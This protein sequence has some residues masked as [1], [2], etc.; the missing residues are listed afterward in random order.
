LQ[1]DLPIIIVVEDEEP[2]QK[3]IALKEGGFDVTTLA[4]GREEVAMISKV[5]W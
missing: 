5:A 2:S 4:S 1:D 3:V